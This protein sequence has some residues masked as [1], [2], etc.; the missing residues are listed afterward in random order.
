M[1]LS[2]GC[3][4]TQLILFNVA[5]DRLDVVSTSSSEKSS[6][7]DW[8]SGK[9][10]NTFQNDPG[11]ATRWLVHS[12]SSSQTANAS[13]NDGCLPKMRIHSS[14][15]KLGSSFDRIPG[16]SNRSGTVC[17]RSDGTKNGDQPLL[18]DSQDPFAFDDDDFVPSKWDVQYGEKKKSRTKKH[19]KLGPR[20]REIQDEHHFQFKMSQ[21]E[22]S[23]G[24]ICQRENE[25]YHHSN[26][27][28]CSQSTEEEYSSLLSDCL[29]AAV[30]VFLNM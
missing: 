3:Y 12:V 26:A 11:P 10:F 16:T 13:S 9:S 30:K 29:L 18:E 8:S 4:L 21:Q 19:G 5:V 23:N 17:K 27:T 25:E 6:S 28:S 2:S 22:S 14:G 15:G 7:L 24:E 20:K 1:F